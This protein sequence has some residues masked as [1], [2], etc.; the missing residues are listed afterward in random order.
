VKSADEE[1]LPDRKISSLPCKTAAS[2]PSTSILIKLAR[3]TPRTASRV[4]D[5]TSIVDLRRRKA[6]SQEHHD[7]CWTEN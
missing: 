3:R 2:E 5:S 1:G 4:V 6:A 7:S